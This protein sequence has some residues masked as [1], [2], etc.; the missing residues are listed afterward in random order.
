MTADDSQLI[1]WRKQEQPIIPHPPENIKLTGF[2]DPYI[3][4]RGDEQKKWKMLLGSGV[5][6]QG[7]TLLVYEA[8]D[9][10][11]GIAASSA[12][13]SSAPEQK[14]ADVCST[15]AIPLDTMQ[16]CDSAPLQVAW[17]LEEDVS[18]ACQWPASWRWIVK[19]AKDGTWEFGNDQESI[20][21]AVHA[22]GWEYKGSF[23]KGKSRPLGEHDLGAMWECPFFT[24]VAS[25]SSD[26]ASSTAPH[27]L[28]LSEDTLYVMCVSPYPHFLKDRPT[29]PC[30][31][32]LGHVKDEVF[33]IE[34]S[35]GKL[36]HNSLLTSQW[37]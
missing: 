9:L 37:M 35:D 1:K 15:I 28:Q 36:G 6:G 29:N 10:A 33:Q 22:A 30:L 27:V 25:S 13:H 4:Q 24:A 20:M 2:R 3:I 7:G 23:I 31:Y 21:E 8:S 34:E 16:R 11:S 32:W 26:N 12:P 5:E 18:Q 17:Q 19:H 14:Q